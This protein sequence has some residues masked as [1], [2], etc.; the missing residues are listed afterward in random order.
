MKEGEVCV[1]V[2]A[3]ARARKRRSDEVVF[4]RGLAGCTVS[5]QEGEMSFVFKSFEWPV[6]YDVMNQRYSVCVSL[7][8]GCRGCP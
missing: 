3:R 1:C 2:C 5:A 6:E 8:G 4:L 7:L